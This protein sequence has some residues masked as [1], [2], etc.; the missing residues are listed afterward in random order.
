MNIALA[1]DHA[2]FDLK[3]SIADYLIQKGIK[4]IDFGCSAGE[5]VDY[6]DYGSRAVESV[7]AGKCERAILFCGTGLGMA[8]VANKYRGIRA[9]P[10]W[11]VHTSEIS[12]THNDSNCLALGGRIL[13]PEEGR[14]IVEAWLSAV[15]EGG[16]HQRRINKIS[17]LERKNFKD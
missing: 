10:C 16:R 4:F 6:V 5:T 14:A 13:S 1:S 9:V 17:E 3:S 8:I 2:G 12:R 11:N 7:C 15:F